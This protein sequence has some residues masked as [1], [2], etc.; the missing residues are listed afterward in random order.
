MTGW[1]SISGQAH[2]DRLRGHQRDYGIGALRDDSS[3]TSSWRAPS[4]DPGLREKRDRRQ[5]PV[6]PYFRGLSSPH[7][8]PDSLDVI[9]SLTQNLL[10]QR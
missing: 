6:S 10:F 2:Q 7:I 8:M 5:K 1:G 9:L 3:L 4:Q